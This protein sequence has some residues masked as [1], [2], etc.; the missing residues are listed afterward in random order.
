MQRLIKRNKIPEEQAL[1][2]IKLQM[3]TWIKVQ[4]ADLIVENSGALR[5]LQ[6]EIKTNIMK[7]ISLRMD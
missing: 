7:E 4:K 1:Q 6:A 3:S 5:E 2:K